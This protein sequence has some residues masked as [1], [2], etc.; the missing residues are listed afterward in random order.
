LISPSVGGHQLVAK[1]VDTRDDISILSVDEDLP[2]ETCRLGFKSDVF[3][4]EAIRYGIPGGFSEPPTAEHIRIGGKV[5]QFMPLVVM[6]GNP[7]EHGESGGPVIN[8][9]NV[10][11]VI[12]GKHKDYTGISFMT[13]GSTV[14]ELLSKDSLGLSG[15]L[16]NPVEASLTL[17]KP[18]F[19]LG[20]VHGGQITGFVSVNPQFA[21]AFPSVTKSILAS[22]TNQLG[23]HSF[24]VSGRSENSVTV[25]RNFNPTEVVSFGVAAGQIARTTEETKEALQKALWAS[26]VDDGTKEGKWKVDHYY[27]GRHRRRKG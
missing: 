11:G 1:V 15:R 12:H 24:N 13:V 25:A 18:A 8:L 22:Y 7:T 10:V 27:A 14:T 20:N 6:S 9:F 3:G 2:S 4:T 5:N 17:R 23:A 26:Y 21:G 19:G 16:C